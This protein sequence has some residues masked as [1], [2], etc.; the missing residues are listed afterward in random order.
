MQPEA[1]RDPAARV[2]LGGALAA[3]AILWPLAEAVQLRPGALFDLR[4]LAVL[5]RFLAAFLPP[6]TGSEF[7]ALLAWAGL[8]TLAIATAGLALAFVLALPLA[9]LASGAA[10]ERPAFNPGARFFLVVLRG[11]PE[12]VWALVFVRV[13]GLGP[14]AGVFALGLTY[15]GMLAKVYAEILESVDARPAL[16][17][18]NAGVGRGLA[19]LYGLLP[20]AAGEL[21]SYT[22]YRWECALR[23]SVVMGFVGAGGLGQLLDQAMKMLNGGET[24]S[25]LLA[26]VALVFAAD[27]LS[28]ALRRGLDRAS[29]ERPAPFGAPG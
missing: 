24:A 8:E 23:A 25:I 18:R 13:F 2:R 4:S 15:G 28:G 19:I 5:G 17:L 7:L 1:L 27:A 6:E 21:L 11:V 16:A 22:V 29:R 20:Q 14:A 3:L 9:F 10:R 26:F 12:L